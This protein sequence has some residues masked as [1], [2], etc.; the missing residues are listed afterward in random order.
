[1]TNG[2]VQINSQAINMT[3]FRVSRQQAGTSTYLV[4]SDGNVRLSTLATIPIDRLQNA[5]RQAFE[6]CPG[7]K[8]RF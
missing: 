4:S 3:A 1:M 5:W 2:R 8:S 6:E 7:T